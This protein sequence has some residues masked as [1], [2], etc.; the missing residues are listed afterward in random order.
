MLECHFAQQNS[1]MD[2]PWIW[3][4]ATVVKSQELNPSAMGNALSHIIIINYLM[5]FLISSMFPAVSSFYKV[6][7]KKLQY[8]EYTL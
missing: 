7:S 1:H 5:L 3:T 4:Q 8:L 6:F 2:C